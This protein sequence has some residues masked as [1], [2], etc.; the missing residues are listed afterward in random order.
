MRLSSKSQYGLKLCYILACNYPDK[1]KSASAL[2]KEIAVS[3]KYIEKI[4][5]LLSG[6]GIVKAERGVSGGYRLA[7][8]PEEITIGDIAR[9]LEDNM[10]IA[11]CITSTC[12]MCATGEVWRKL[13]AGINEVVDS[14]TLRSML[15]DHSQGHICKCP[16]ERCNSSCGSDCNCKV[17]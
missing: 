14:M 7:K 12:N 6:N 8:A 10:E 13:Y 9:A 15:D 4:M 5:R 2:E 11:D 3:G 16:S 17:V 1:R